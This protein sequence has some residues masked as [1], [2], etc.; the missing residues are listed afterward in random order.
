MERLKINCQSIDRVLEIFGT[1]V[2]EPALR[3]A[4]SLSGLLQPLQQSSWSDVKYSFSRLTGDGF[5]VEF[6]FSSATTAISYTTEIAGPELDERKKVGLA[7]A[8]L[9]EKAKGLPGNSYSPDSYSAII[10]RLGQQPDL[11]YGAW[12]AGR[13][14]NGKNDR[15]KIY[16]EVTNTCAD[17]GVSCLKRFLPDFSAVN[18]HQCLLRMLSVN[19]SGK[20]EYYFRLSSL[21]VWQL[22]YLLRCFGFANQGKE[23][24][25]FVALLSKRKFDRSFIGDSL[26]LSIA[27]DEHGM[28]EAA[29]IF[30]FNFKV[31]EPGDGSIR[32]SVLTYS[33]W[34]GWDF[35][36]YAQ[37][38]EPLASTTSRFT[39][40]GLVAFTTTTGGQKI[41]Q[42]GLRPPEIQ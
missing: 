39:N 31:F 13:H 20:L 23:L 40:H 37:I 16:L 22:L 4:A 26:G 34:F 36:S 2:A 30:T 35:A 41:F 32:R 1:N 19:T 3:A 14:D 28:P 10:N 27:L 5:P 18:S 38:T 29:T 33:D 7:A 25:E 15:F 8:L 24:I 9:Q 42:V 6:T 11:T 17:I 12:M 21:D